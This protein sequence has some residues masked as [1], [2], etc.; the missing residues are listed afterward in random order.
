MDGTRVK[1]QIRL[2]AQRVGQLQARKDSQGQIT[3]GDIVTLLREGNVSLARAKAQKLIR[4]DAFGDVLEVLGMHLGTIIEHFSELERSAPSPSLV[5][6]TSTVIYASPHVE[7]KELLLVRDVLTQ[8]LGPDFARSAM[9]NRDNY[10]SSKVVRALNMPLPSIASLDEFLS[11]IAKSAGVKWTPD[12]S[13]EQRVDALSELL[14]PSSQVPVVDMPRLR[15]LCIHGIP[16]HPPWLRP[17]IWRLLLGTL[18]VLRAGWPTE[19]DKHRDN[20][21]DLVSRLL[22][23]FSTLPPPQNPLVPLDDELLKVYRELN[24]VPRS[25]FSSLE[26]ESEPPEFPPLE[27]AGPQNNRLSCLDNLNKRL[28]LIQA[29]ENGDLSEKYTPEIRLESDD[30]DEPSAVTVAPHQTASTTLFPSQPFNATPAP[31]RHSSALLRLL[32]VHTR[33]NPAHRS[34][35]IASLLLPVYTVLSCELDIQDLA[36][37]EADT[38]WVFEAMVSEFSELEDEEG[39]GIWMQRLGERLAWADEDLA[40]NLR[41]KG[42]DPALPH[43]SYRWLAPLLTHTLPLAAVCAVWDALFSRPSATKSSNP[44]LDYLLDICTSMLIRAK[45]PLARLGKPNYK[46]SGL[47]IEDDSLPPPSPLRVWE[48]S[49][50][51]MEGMSLLQ[52]YPVDAVGGVESILTTAMEL[53]H[54]REQQ[55][56]STTVVNVS[57]S[58][59]LR[60]TMWRGFTNQVADVSPEEDLTDDDEDD[61][62]EGNETETAETQETSVLT[63]RLASTVWKGFMNQSSVVTPTSPQPPS[64]PLPSS[65]IS[66]KSPAGQPSGLTS[67]L[68]TTVWRGITNQSSMDV[69]SSPLPP[70]S[71]AGSGPHSPSTSSVLITDSLAPASA[72][73]SIWDY[74]E[75]LKDSDTAATLAKVSTNWKVKALQAWNRNSA[76]GIS[77]TP[78]SPAGL[79]SGRWGPSEGDRRDSFGSTVS[80]RIGGVSNRG[81]VFRPGHSDVYSP[82]PRPAFFRPPRDSMF[83]QPRRELSGYGSSNDDESPPSDAGI[84]D[85]TKHLQASLASLTGLQEPSQNSRPKSG[86]RPLLLSSSS[87]MTGSNRVS[88]AASVSNTS[89]PHSK[90][91]SEVM[92]TKGH[93][94]RS[95]SQSSTSTSLSVS[96][97]G[98]RLDWESDVAGGRVVP[99]HR[100]RSPMAPNFR[101]S[102]ERPESI[103]STTSS[104]NGNSRL[105]SSSRVTARKQADSSSEKGW[106]RVDLP[107]SPTTLPSSP[108]P[109]TPTTSML[110]TTGVSVQNP[111]HQRGSV[112]LSESQDS[113]VHASFEGRKVGRKKTPPVAE[114]EASEA[115]DSSA[116][117]PSRGVRSRYKKVPARLA[118]LR[119]QDDMQPNAVVEPSTPSPNNLA[120]DSMDLDV[121]STPKAATFDINVGTPIPP[122]SRSPRR[123]RKIS[124]EGRDVRTRKISSEGRARKTSSEDRRVT[125]SGAEEGDDEGYDDLLSAYESEDG[126]RKDN[127]K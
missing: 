59:R 110:F 60:D 73:S 120:P 5:E 57:L 42:L 92:H 109:R 88:M 6:A 119:I 112:V 68:A 123:L 86:P 100:A 108:P 84:L 43:Y 56:K 117:A 63:S 93:P 9:N 29:A 17:R 24:R 20:Y 78:S 106:G 122:R 49:D 95:A 94:M 104:D 51:F 47:W 113:P 74:A 67:R 39:G 26:E 89:V 30:D 10:V 33:L 11:A 41:A 48:R 61:E 102:R 1:A 55:I 87:L 46:V 31:E 44:K 69:P 105:S 4:E 2:A 65:T 22:E 121:A 83:P 101:F 91:W 114:L 62:D 76:S 45:I 12:L 54:R 35:H 28:R 81:S 98:D 7:C 96:R 85:K 16:D 53:L 19:A 13:P 99:L 40:V 79:L 75:K 126:F 77:S 3:R 80:E 111:D 21:Y 124:T 18:P 23:P 127:R 116:P 37:V 97:P 52:M 71:P 107:D 72:R 32:Y 36:H 38:F 27:G 82:P 14:D 125:D 8:E 50:A 58:T 25:L 103:S 115:S 90:Q 64:S 70:S 15:S 34:P 118:A 66:P